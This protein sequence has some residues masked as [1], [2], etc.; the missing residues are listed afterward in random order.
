VYSANL[1]NQECNIA[2]PNFFGKFQNVYS[3]FKVRRE[4]NPNFNEL[5]NFRGLEGE[6][7]NCYTDNPLVLNGNYFPARDYQPQNRIA[8]SAEQRIVA[9]TTNLRVFNGADFVISA[10]QAITFEPGFTADAGAIFEARIAPC[11][12]TRQAH[13][14]HQSTPPH[15]QVVPETKPDRLNAYP[16]PASGE[17]TF[18]YSIPETGTATLTVSDLTGRVLATVLNEKHE[19]VGEYERAFSTAKLPAGVY[20]YTLRVGSFQQTK[21]FVVLR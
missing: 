8:I 12:I 6:D 7:I 16:N 3:E 10:S 9:G 4:L 20:L 11:G 2:G 17:V 5:V 15:A 19:W 13:D 14:G 21:R 1:F 18:R